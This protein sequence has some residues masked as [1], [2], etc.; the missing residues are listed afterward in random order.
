MHSQAPLFH[1]YSNQKSGFSHYLPRDEPHRATPTQEDRIPAPLLPLGLSSL[2][3]VSPLTARRVA[4][5]SLTPSPLGRLYWEQFLGHVLG[6]PAKHLEKASNKVSEEHH[7]ISSHT[8]TKVC[9]YSPRF[10]NANTAKYA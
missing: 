5:V 1:T 3:T 7:N 9:F 8:I 4:P 10:S 2:S 6:R